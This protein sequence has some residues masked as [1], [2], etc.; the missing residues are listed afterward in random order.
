MSSSWYRSSN[1]SL[2]KSWVIAG[3]YCGWR[4]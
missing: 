1:Y 3:E 4:P 2:F